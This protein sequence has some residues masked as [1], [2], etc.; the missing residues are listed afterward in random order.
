MQILQH[1]NLN[2]LDL[3][4]VGVSIA[5]IGI[6]G[7]VVYYN[8]K[9]SITN[10]TFLSFAFLTAVY[11]IFNY[12]NYKV[13]SPELILWFLRLT[14][15]SAVWHAF[16]LFQFFFVF[17]K[18]K[19]KFPRW[20]FKILI[21]ATA[22][23]SF[24]TLTP[25]VFSR[26]EQ[27]AA[28]GK[29]SNP[30]RGPAIALFGA[31]VVFLVI[32]S[33]IILLKKRAQAHNLERKQYDTITVGTCLT[34]LLILCFNFFL[35]VV[36]NNLKFIPLAPVFFLPFIAF[37]TVA[38]VRFHL[39]N[40]K[41]ITTEILTFLLAVSSLFEVLISEDIQT[42]AFR[43]GIFLLILNISFL[44]NKS[45]RNEVE[46]KEQ[47]QL[48][49]DKLADANEKLK[50]LDQARSEFITI[51]S[52][53]LRTPPATIKWYLSAVL[54]GDFG[55]IT[56]EQKNVI[57]KA[58]RTNNSQISLIDDMLNVSR[59]ERGKMEFMFE[60]TDLLPLAQITYEQ[61]IPPSIEKGLQLKFIAPSKPLPKIMADKEKIR[62]VMNNLIDNA[63]KY[64]KQGSITAKLYTQGEEILFSVTDTGKGIGPNE[65]TS[66][67][68]KFSRGKE[69]V[70]QSAGLGLGL[71]V[72]KVVIEQHKGKIWAESE[73]DG[74][75]STFVFSLPIHT[76]L[77]ATTLLDL[78]KN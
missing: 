50:A 47:L 8:N 51:A 4:A 56:E 59:I 22:L 40:A 66:I 14:I 2:N 30:E 65:K 53:Q 75:G 24:L 68:E 69:S 42:A 37:T 20:Y 58:N 46:Q 48:L 3:L 39:L 25:L 19:I 9:N 74:K 63:L 45:V 12:I 43:F 72:A 17:P 35:P 15:F 73:G 27:I 57:D 7:F 21:P 16:S 55:K 1:L 64:T 62:Q 33:L 67:F 10:Q 26:I 13:R 41:I 44:L 38:I 49:S 23:T 11:G 52:H 70:R 18:D 61:L 78:T 77:H 32:G 36:F 29:V 71:Y 76:D 31:M 34:F 54:A 5:A 28:E 60:E 6:L